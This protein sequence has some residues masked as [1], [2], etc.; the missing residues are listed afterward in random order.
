MIDGSAGSKNADAASKN[1]DETAATNN[2]EQ[3]LKNAEE[4]VKNSEVGIDPITT[5]STNGGKTIVKPD[6]GET[7]FVRA[8]N[9]DLIQFAFDLGAVSVNLSDVDMVITFPDGARIILVEFGMLIAADLAPEFSFNGDIATGQDMMSLVGN[10]DAANADKVSF[11]SMKDDS[12]TKSEEEIEEDEA[13]VNENSPEP[14]QAPPEDPKIDNKKGNSFN[15]FDQSK[16]SEK[17]GVDVKGKFIEEASASASA[18]GISN[19]LPDS[20]I[21]LRVLGLTEQSYSTMEDG[22]TLIVGAT[23]APPSDTDPGY[24][25]QSARETIA[26]TSNADVIYADSQDYAPQGTSSRVLEVTLE[27]PFENWTPTSLIVTNLPPGMGIL[28][29]EETAKGYKLELTEDTAF[30]HSLVLNYTMP[31]EGAPQDENG[32]FDIDSI[33]IEYTLVDPRGATGQSLASAP[34]GLRAVYE[35]GDLYFEDL[36]TGDVITAIDAAPPGNIINAGAGDDFIYAGAGADQIDGGAGNDWV[37]YAISSAAVNGDLGGN[38][39]NGGYANWHIH[40]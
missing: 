18:T 3:N 15:E 9:L 40:H 6:A 30:L 27:L 33:S 4:A 34:V 32:F 38:I 10:F 5:A 11:T 20:E 23:S 17:V 36:A 14:Q 7:V 25:I 2:A 22:R 13:S 16:I 26:G 31:V 35:D 24:G 29:A 19:I 12:D 8:D 1:T 28:D 39:F 21:T 37:S